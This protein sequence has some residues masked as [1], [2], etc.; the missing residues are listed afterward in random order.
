MQL[1][2]RLN[3]CPDPACPGHAKCWAASSLEKSVG[4][5]ISEKQDAFVTGTA[6]EFPGVPQRSVASSMTTKGDRFM[7]PVYASKAL[8][9]SS[10]A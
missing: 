8:K 2:C 5:W 4:L 7:L 9:L 10:P 6:A 1:V 3:H